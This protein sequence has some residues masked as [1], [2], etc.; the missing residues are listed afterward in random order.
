[1]SRVGV[2][3]DH[4]IVRESRIFDVG[5]LAVTRN[6]FRSLQHPIHLSEINIAEQRRNHSALRNASFSMGP[7]HYL[8]QMHH[9]GVVHALCYFRQQTIL[10]NIVEVAAQV[11]VDDP[12]LLTDNGFG[13]TGYRFMGC[14]IGSVSKRSRLKV[15]LKDRFQYQLERPL[16]HA[17]PNS[18]NRKDSDFAPILRYLLPSSR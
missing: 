6:I 2:Y 10:S 3:Q 17:V 5:V 7:E 11:N 8:Q 18:R 15:R 16:R 12:R 13:Y 1:M 4:Q 9:V 14:P